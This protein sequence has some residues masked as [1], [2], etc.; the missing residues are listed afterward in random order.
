M[1]AKKATALILAVTL[2]FVLIG[3]D[4]FIPK[5]ENPEVPDTPLAVTTDT[6]VPELYESE[7][8]MD[9]P[10]FPLVDTKCSIMMSYTMPV[11]EGMKISSDDTGV[12]AARFAPM[13]DSED[14][15]IVNIME[16]P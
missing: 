5:Q 4:F 16:M 15:S 14:Q 11:P 8:F 9:T 6:W 2:S 12:Y 1:Y 13:D 7:L 10:V 3:C